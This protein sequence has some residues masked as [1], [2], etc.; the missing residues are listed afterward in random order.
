MQKF[1]VSGQSFPKVEW[2]QTDGRRL[3]HYLPRYSAVGKQSAVTEPTHVQRELILQLDKKLI[4]PYTIIKLSTRHEI[5]WRSLEII[6]SRL[7]KQIDII[8]YLSLHVC[9][10]IA[11]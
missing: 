4:I 7:A 11:N 10:Q 2:K 3:L 5:P 8:D 9:R 6:D 1:K